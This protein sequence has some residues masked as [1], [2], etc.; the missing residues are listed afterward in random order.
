MIAVVQRVAEGS[1]TVGS[2]PIASI[3]RGLVVLLAV[4]RDDSEA[5]AAWMA[6]KLAGLRIFPDESGQK[7][8]DL[9]VRAVGGRIL[10]VSNFTV[11]AD[12]SAGR[13]P[14]L[15]PAASPREAEPIFRK[16]VELVAAGGVEVHTGQFGADMQVAL[17]ND[18]PVTFLIRT[19]R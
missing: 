2:K 17:V 14:S 7:P 10:L 8:L 4:E 12:C 9:D 13:R 15:E 3:G 6:R 1:V 11:A 16:V 18:G 19:P 5:D